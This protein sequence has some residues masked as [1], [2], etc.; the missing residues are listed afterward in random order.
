MNPEVVALERAALAAWPAEEA[1]WHHGWCFRAM[2]GVTRRANSVWAGPLVQEAPLAPAIG[3]AE[4]FYAVRGLPC[5]F[6]VAPGAA[7]DTLD[8]ALA[9]RGYE[10]EAPVS[11]RG[12]SLLLYFPPE[13]P[14]CEVAVVIEREPSPRWFDL[15]ASG[16]FSGV[17]E[18]YRGL[19]DRLGDRAAYARVELDGRCVA[20]GLGVVDGERCGLFA[21]HTEP[22]YRRRGL[23]RRIVEAI[24]SHAHGRGAR[25]LYLQVERDNEAAL[26]LYDQ[27]GFVERYGYH[28]RRQCD[29]PSARTS[30][31][32]LTS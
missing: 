7:P 19:L 5:L 23:A 16:R 12:R 24:A 13:R 22:A 21:M 14:A 17:Q 2:R 32:T 20:V 28:Y 8:G 27:L 29:S 18:V 3:A 1:V 4:A 10:V 31:G 6:Q 25:D 15:S 9:A 11:V 26:A 30:S